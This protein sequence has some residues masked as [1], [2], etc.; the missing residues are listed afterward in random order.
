M[1]SGWSTPLSS[2]RSRPPRWPG[3]TSRSPSTRWA[4][5]RCR[6]GRVRRGRSGPRATVIRWS[7]AWSWPRSARPPPRPPRRPCRSP[8]G[9]G[10]EPGV[11]SGTPTGSSPRARR[12]WNRHYPGCAPRPA[13]GHSAALSTPWPPPHRRSAQSARRFPS[14]SGPQIA[15]IPGTRNIR[16]VGLELPFHPRLRWTR[17]RQPSARLTRPPAPA[18][19]PV[20]VLPCIQETASSLPRSPQMS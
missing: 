7:R 2:P 20:T 12:P 1:T 16:H 13:P 9:S 17:I 18:W 14:V 10:P 6:R 8:R 5:K 19:P 4:V 3:S 11:T 15:V